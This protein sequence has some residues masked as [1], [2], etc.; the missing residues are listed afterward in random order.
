MRRI[1]LMLAAVLCASLLPGAGPAG[2]GG[3]TEVLLS[4]QANELDVYDVGTLTPGMSRRTVIHAHQHSPTPPDDNGNDVNGQN[5]R[6][7]QSNGATRFVMG[8]DSDQSMYPVGEVQGWGL[9]DPTSEHWAMRDKLIPTY[10]FTDPPNQ[11]LP[12]NTGCAVSADGSL[13]FLVDLGVGAFDVPGVGSLFVYF[14]DAGGDF[15][16]IAKPAA[17]RSK[18]CVLANNLTTAGYIA[19]APD[20]SVLV[21]QTGRSNGGV[22]ERFAP[23]FPANGASCGSYPASQR[24]DFIKALPSYVPIS[25][26]ARNGSWLVGNVV[27]GMVSEYDAA[28]NWV[29]LIVPPGP[30]N[31]AGMAVSSDGT[32]YFANLGLR[33]DPEELF[34][35]QDLAGALYM[36]LFLPEVDVPLPPVLIQPLLT[37]PEGLG[38][39][40]F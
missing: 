9:F 40:A 7:T 6:V 19:V 3:T 37:F 31:V 1:A 20:G 18:Y 15:S 4:A 5:C 2:A 17:S 27:P 38:I 36:V 13:L 28:G 33:P 35:T 16:G 34:T 22:V 23:P 8:E 39:H 14:R 10:N 32:L 25:I 12:D 26:A 11:H 30:Y 21:P 29:R 24:S